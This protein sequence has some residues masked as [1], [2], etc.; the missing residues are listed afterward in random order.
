M[1]YFNIDM[2]TTP[3]IGGSCWRVSARLFS[4]C[5]LLLAFLF[6]VSPHVYPEVASPTAIPCR[7][8]VSGKLLSATFANFFVFEQICAML[9]ENF[10]RFT[11]SLVHHKRSTPA[12]LNSA[13]NGGGKVVVGVRVVARSNI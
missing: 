8:M 10:C 7:G 6:T 9:C 13:P 1:L 3:P 11:Y 2:Q 5:T 4:F 12:S